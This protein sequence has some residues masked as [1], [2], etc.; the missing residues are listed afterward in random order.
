MSKIDIRLL[1][2]KHTDYCL[3][4]IDQIAEAPEIYA[5]CP[6]CDM[7]VSEGEL[8]EEV[9]EYIAWLEEEL[10]AALSVGEQ[11]LL[12]LDRIHPPEPANHEEG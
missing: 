6:E 9:E 10:E 12:T 4:T 1:Y 11:L 2:Q 7:D 5:T 3:Q 8:G